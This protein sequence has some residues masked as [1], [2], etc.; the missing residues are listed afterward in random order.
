MYDD[1]VE[2]PRRIGFVATRISGTDGVSLEIQKWAEVLERLGHACF[3]IAGQSDRP[4]D[5]SMVVP[6]AHFKHPVVQEISRQSFGRQRRN[7]H[8]SSEIHEMTWVIKEKLHS[9]VQRFGLDLIIAENCL[10]IPMNV[11][12]GLAV[13]EMVME[14]GLGCIAHHHDFVWERERFLVNAVD[15]HLLTAFP[16]AL[17]QIQHVVINSQAAREFS[18]RTGLPCRVIPNV[19]DFD[20]P[21]P[22]PD[23]YAH[24][25][26]P[27][28]GLKPEDSLILQPTR[29][30]QRKGIEHS[31]ELVRRLDDSRCKLVITHTSGDEGEQYAERI[32]KYA[33]LMG[34]DVIFAADR[35][36]HRRGISSEGQKQYTIWDAYQQADLI[37]YPSTY[38]GFGNA[39]LEAV[40]YRKP[41]LCN[42]YA[43]YRTDIEPCGFRAVLLE[44][45]VTDEVVDEVRCLL[46]DEVRRREIAEHN[47]KV[48]TRFFSYGRVED[49]LRAILAKP[50]LSPPEGSPP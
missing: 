42:R 11:P 45:F 1:P 35:I 19:M 4:A 9:A 31:I 24:E 44:G 16:P 17:P 2:R 20:R 30:V 25:F 49:E 6:E 50:T 33:A 26:R 43:I 39:F 37:T 3:Y 22:P 18:R 14:T 7:R 13:V 15:D 32:R 10:T 47:Y 40:Y 5:R 12:L 21:P 36:A 48:A 8:L 34:V 38:E 41:I 28:L 29:L 46:A 23:D 27:M